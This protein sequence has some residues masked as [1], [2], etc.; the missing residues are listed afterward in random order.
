MSNEV[1][2]FISNEVADLFAEFEGDILA[3]VLRIWDC[4]AQDWLDGTTTIFRFENDDVLVWDEMGFLMARN[5]PVDTNTVKNDQVWH[6]GLQNDD[7]LCVCWRFAPEF[8]SFVGRSNCIG[9]L[10]STLFQL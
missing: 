9:E 3:D 4:D 10:L 1:L 8:S 6:E 7:H 2:P 5:G